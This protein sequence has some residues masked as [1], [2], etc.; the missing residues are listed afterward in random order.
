[1]KLPMCKSAGE[2]ASALEALWAAADLA[3]KPNRCAYFMGAWMTVL[4][5]MD[6]KSNSP[7]FRMERAVAYEDGVGDAFDRGHASMWRMI[8]DLHA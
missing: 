3:G 7:I 4:D 5:H 2:Y 6:E 8:G 1:M